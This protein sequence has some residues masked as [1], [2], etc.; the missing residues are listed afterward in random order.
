MNTTLSPYGYTNNDKVYLYAYMEFPEREIGFVRENE[1]TSIEY[2]TKRFDLATAKVNELISAIKES[3]NKGSYL[4]KLIHL[5]QYLAEFNALGDFS[6]LFAKLDVEEVEIREY[7]LH[8]RGKNLEIKTA[9]LQEAETLKHSTAWGDTA[10]K[11]KDLKLKWIKTGS[12]PSENE[13]ELNEKFNAVLDYFFE[14]RNAFVTEKN[15]QIEERKQQYQELIN[16]LRKVVN[17]RSENRIDQIKQLQADWRNVGMIPKR[18]FV[19]YSRIFKNELNYFFSKR[20]ENQKPRTPIE[21][22]EDMCARVEKMLENP[23]NVRLDEIRKIQEDWKKLGKLPELADKDLNTK[24]KIICNEIFEYNFL[25]K[26]AKTKYEGYIT[27]TRFEQLKLKIRLLKETL[28]EDEISLTMMNTERNKLR[29][30]TEQPP[31]TAEHIN[32]INK[33]KTKQRI[34][35]KL[36]DQL[37]ETY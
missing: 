16:K 9:L 10:D 20:K 37:D 5:R 1:E 14:R 17:E 26:T 33:I 13:E 25:V 11:F 18:Q 6:S 24:F 29:Y 12:S 19:F 7:I 8:N 31:M 30:G 4:M 3:Q 28:K 32:L 21:Q 27:K 23:D 15:R 36:Q 34:L 2:F 35:K 22:K